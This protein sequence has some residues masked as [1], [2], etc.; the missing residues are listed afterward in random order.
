MSSIMASVEEGEIKAQNRFLLTSRTGDT[1]GYTVEQ[2]WSE[3][4]S[5]GRWPARQRIDR[6]DCEIAQRAVRPLKQSHTHEGNQ[7]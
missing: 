2:Y 3:D 1:G 5:C 6:R 4:V 7:P